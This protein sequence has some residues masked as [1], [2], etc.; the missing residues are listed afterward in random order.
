MKIDVDWFKKDVTKNNQKNIVGS[1]KTNAEISSNI[2]NIEKI[3]IS[4]FNM[5]EE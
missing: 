1:N 2:H 5:E 4:D 3:S